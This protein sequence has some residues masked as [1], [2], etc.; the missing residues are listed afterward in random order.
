MKKKEAWRTSQTYRVQ[1]TFL[2]KRYRIKENSTIQPD[3]FIP[4]WHAQQ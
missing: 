3:Q 1:Q 4:K 2:R